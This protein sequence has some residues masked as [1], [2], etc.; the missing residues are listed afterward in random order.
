MLIKASDYILPLVIGKK[1]SENP[2]AQLN[3]FIG[4]AFYI[5]ANGVIATCGHIAS[6]PASD[7]S[8][9]VYD[10]NLQRFLELEM[11]QIHPEMDFA[12]ARTGI[13]HNKY[14]RLVKTETHPIE[15]GTNIS[16]FGYINAGRVGSDLHLEDKYFKGYISFIGTNPDTTLRCRT[17][18]ELS[19]PVL[20]GFSGAPVFFESKNSLVG[21]LY[22]NRESKIEVYSNT[23]VQIKG[24]AVTKKQPRSMALG[25][26][27]TVNDIVT[28]IKDMG[29]KVKGG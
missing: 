16:S 24:K 2:F 17:V 6:T 27:H 3:R 12:I 4:T 11:L 9:M 8:L 14:L 26:M 18:C 28:F 15:L 20:N 13:K 7:E 22:G 25:L 21:M 5:G 19:F 29:I 1:N 23:P 10:L